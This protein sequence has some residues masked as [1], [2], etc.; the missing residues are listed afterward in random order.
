[1]SITGERDDLPGGGPQKV[2][3]AV[4][5][6]TTGMY[7]TV[8]VLPAL[9]HRSRTGEGQYIDMALLDVQV[10]MIANMNMNYLVSGRVPKRQGNAHANIV[11]YQVFDA[12][13]GQMVLA[14]G[15]DSQFAKFCTVAGSQLAQDDR[16]RKNAD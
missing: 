10:A 12:A 14:V 3:V 16:F 9:A 15:N 7:A 5:D 1:M 11:P 6:I 2:G 4:A 13:D 8:A